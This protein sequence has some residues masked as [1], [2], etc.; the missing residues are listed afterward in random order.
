MLSPAEK[1]CTLSS[2]IF[3]LTALLTGVWKW[4][5][6]A[7]SKSGEASKYVNT[8]HRSSLLYSFA[9]L[10]L[11]RFT[12]LNNFSENVNYYSVVP[13]LFFFGSAIGT[14][15]IHGVLQDTN[16]Q[17]AKPRLG[18]RILPVWVTPLFMCSLVVAEIGGFLVLFYGFV[19]A[20]YF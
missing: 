13:P 1:L 19:V 17:I 3:F 7:T 14:Y 8:A 16:N 10:L 5:E 6:M 15:L 12:T 11:G 18:K 20:E 9:A 2:G 4:R